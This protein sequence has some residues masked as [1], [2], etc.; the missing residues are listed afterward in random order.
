MYKVVWVILFIPLLVIQAC[1]SSS[2]STPIDDLSKPR[3][4]VKEVSPDRGKSEERNFEYESKWDEFYATPHD[5]GDSLVIGLIGDSDSLNPLTLETKNA[6]DIADLLFLSLTRINPDYSSAPSL[7]QSWEFSNNHREL[8]F[9]LRDDVRWHDGVKT[10]AHDVCFTLEKQQ[11]PNTGY[12][13]IKDKKYIKECVVLDD[14]TAK[15]VFKQEYPYQ[16]MDAVGGH[17]VPKHIL[18]KI[19]EGEMVRADFN[20]SPVGNGPFRFKEWKAQQYIQLEA[21]Q[22]YFAGRPSIDRIIFKVVPD[23]ENLVIQLR[24]GQIDFMERIPPRFYEDLSQHEN[25]VAHVHPSRSYTY[26]GWNLRDPR[27]RKRKIRQ[28]LTL[29]INRQEIID[30]LLLEFGDICEGPILPILW[31][32]NPHLPSFPYDPETAKRYLAEEG[33]RDTDG[34]GWLDKDGQK[35][36]FTLKTNKGNQIREDITILIQDMLKE[37]GVEVR[38][39]ILEWTILVNDSTRKEFEAILLGWS[40]NLKVDMTTI[41]HSESIEDKF[42]FVSYSNLEFDRLND[43]AVMEMDEEKARQMWWQAQAMIVEDQPYTF[44][45]TRKQIN[46]VHERFQNVQME[47]VGWH[48]NLPQWWVIKNQQHY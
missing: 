32:H 46:F 43:T 19:P 25:L 21:S 36:S 20:R 30:S 33:W 4:V 11:D 5:Q 42:N 47:T 1:T 31:A 35:F 41:W 26:I 13:N 29:A 6:Q 2:T 7:A 39:N 23:Q 37:I 3:L 18:E 14:Y 40:V 34:D 16:L 9:Q 48:Y 8:T 38:P 45:F 17:I 24:S 27:F 12:S 10:T 15:F 28:A 22:D 44:L